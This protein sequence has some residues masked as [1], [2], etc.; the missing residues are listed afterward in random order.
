[1]SNN[2]IKKNYTKTEDRQSLV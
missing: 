2:K 1:M